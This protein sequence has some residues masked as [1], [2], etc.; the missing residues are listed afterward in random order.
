MKDYFVKV[1]VNDPYPKHHEVTEKGSN[2]GI[3]IK[4][5]VQRF[6]KEKWNRRPL[7]EITIYAKSL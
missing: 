1:S 7:K 4:R 2:I 5:A 6:R 3:A